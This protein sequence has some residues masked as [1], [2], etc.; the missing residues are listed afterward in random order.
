MTFTLLGKGPRRQNFLK[1]T[2]LDP[3]TLC[4]SCLTQPFDGETG[5]C[6]SCTEL[7]KILPPPEIRSVSRQPREKT[8]RRIPGNPVKE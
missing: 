6:A 5:K 2:M 4:P 7:H 8:V 1:A 3:P